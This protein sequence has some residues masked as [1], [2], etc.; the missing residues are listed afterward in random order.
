MSWLGK[1]KE[2]VGAVLMLQDLV[3]SPE[4]DAK[5][6]TAFVRDAR[7]F[8]FKHSHVISIAPCQVYS[9]AIVFS[10]ENSVVKQSFLSELPEWLLTKPETESDWD[11]VLH[12]WVFN[13]KSQQHCYIPKRFAWTSLKKKIGVTRI[14]RT[15]LRPMH[16]S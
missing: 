10:P 7:R 15:E 9:S 4:S 3:G 5:K 1:R 12:A 2:V 11:S 13:N 16:K 14:A 8:F 6:A